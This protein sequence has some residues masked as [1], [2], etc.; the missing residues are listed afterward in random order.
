[1]KLY[2]NRPDPEHC[3]PLLSFNIKGKDSEMVA[4]F[5]NKEGIA[6]R[7]G[8]HCAPLAHNF[9]NTLETGA[10]RVCPSYFTK[11]SDIDYFVMTIRRFEK[12]YII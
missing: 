3:V 4:D 8:M 6:V 11:T 12:K 1:M 5:L 2:T 7:A 9:Y 10:I